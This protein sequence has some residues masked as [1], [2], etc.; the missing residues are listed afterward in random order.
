MIYLG[1][2][3]QELANDNGEMLQIAQEALD[4]FNSKYG[5]GDSNVELN[6][7]KE[8]TRANKKATKERERF[9]SGEIDLGSK[10]KTAFVKRNL[11]LE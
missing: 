11:G 6:Y 3:M 5:K 4:K 1:I 2:R 9:E 10:A 7:E 8:L